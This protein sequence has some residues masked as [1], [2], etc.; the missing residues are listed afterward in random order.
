MYQNDE[1]YFVLKH[2]IIGIATQQI[3]MIGTICSK[4]NLN[5]LIT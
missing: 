3:L 4:Y 5:W 1:T 2:A